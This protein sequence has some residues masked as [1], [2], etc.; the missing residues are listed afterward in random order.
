MIDALAVAVGATA[1]AR[2]DDALLHRP[3]VATYNSFADQIVREHA[4]R[5]GRDAE[6][7]VLSESAAWLL[8]RRVV[9]ASD[10]PRSRC[11]T[12]LCAPSSMRRC[13]SR[14]TAS[15]IS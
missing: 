1:E 3:T 15:T 10:D 12:K 13:A 4:V 14:A 6:A 8:M 2:D 9:F 5:I 11:V 7:V